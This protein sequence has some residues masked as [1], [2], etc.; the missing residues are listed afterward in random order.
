MN[1]GETRSTALSIPGVLIIT[2]SEKD[3]V[4]EA[5][6]KF[7]KLNGKLIILSHVYIM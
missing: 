6:M 5:F 1:L 3:E 7:V 4:D 2:A